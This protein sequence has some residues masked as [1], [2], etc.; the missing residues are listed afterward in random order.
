MAD[1]TSELH[2]ALR[3]PGLP[4]GRGRRFLRQF[5]LVERVLDYQPDADEEAL[6]R[7]YVFAMVR[8]GA[9]KTALR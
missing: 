5:E 8:H 9:Q 2:T 6:N 3:E 4:T 1:D 7:A